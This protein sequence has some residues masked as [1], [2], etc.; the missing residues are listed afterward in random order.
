M[1][2][3][4]LILS[5]M[6]ICP[7]LSGCSGPAAATRPSLSG[8]RSLMHDGMRVSAEDEARSQFAAANS[9]LA[10]ERGDLPK[11]AAMYREAIAINP[12]NSDA[13]WRLALL[14]VRQ[15]EF[16]LA[17]EVFENAVEVDPQNPALCADFGYHLYLAGDL[18]RAEKFLRHTVRL[19]PGD[20]RASNN[21]GLVLAARGRDE[22]SLAAFLDAGC[23]QAEAQSNLAIAQLLR[24]D[25]STA[26]E[27]LKTSLSLDPANPRAISALQQL[28]AVEQQSPTDAVTRSGYAT[29]D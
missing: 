14:H 15:N 19:A 17:T 8:L 2:A 4:R 18:E 9:R 24:L 25:S 27:T 20:K 11:A 13:L 5:A 10:E 7:A 3:R 23:T 21:L 26:A 12:G 1:N 16:D 22:E 29:M 28:T 6:L